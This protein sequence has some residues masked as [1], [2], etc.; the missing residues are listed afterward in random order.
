MGR[1]AS[2][3]TP[4]KNHSGTDLPLTIL[5]QT[6]KAATTA[7]SKS[8]TTRHNNKRNNQ[9][10]VTSPVKQRHFRSNK[11]QPKSPQPPNPR[12][13]PQPQFRTCFKM[14]WERKKGESGESNNNQQNGEKKALHHGQRK[15]ESGGDL[16][17]RPPFRGKFIFGV[18]CRFYEPTHNICFMT[19]ACNL[20][21]ILGKFPT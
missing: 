11:K 13:P 6:N 18:I 17:W 4:Q 8:S 1:D 14:V 2:F 16:P 19:F 7:T 3:S 12:Q 20:K 10:S 21:V 5:H 15:K 9:P